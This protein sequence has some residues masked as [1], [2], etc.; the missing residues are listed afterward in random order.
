MN[1]ARSR[2]AL[3]HL[4]VEVTERIRAS[5]LELSELELVALATNMAAVELKYL[6]LA[7][8]TLGDRLPPI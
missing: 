3:E 7:C 2:L 4:T 5:C 8:P 1:D 6:G